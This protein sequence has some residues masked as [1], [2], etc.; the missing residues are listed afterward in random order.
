[1]TIPKN[2]LFP[3]FLKLEKLKVLVVGGGNVALEK[4]NALV[5]NSPKTEITLV[6]PAILQEIRSL[7][8]E[9]P[10]IKLKERF[11]FQ[12]DLFNADLVIVA[13]A[14][15]EL[16]RTIQEEAKKRQIL[17]NVADTPELCD[18]Y[19]GSIVSKGDLKIAVSTNGKSPTFAKRI[20]EILSDVFPEETQLVLDN[21]EIIRKKLNGNFSDK[22]KRLNEITSTLALGNNGTTKI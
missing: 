13:T 22:I 14:D 21:L 16:N 17:V 9:Y 1:M 2:A 4:I 8:L 7:S 11:F 15:R 3:V 20:K 19:L 10:N 5:G 12:G 18:F 6:A